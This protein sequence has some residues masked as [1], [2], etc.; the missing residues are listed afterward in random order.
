MSIFRRLLNLPSLEEEESHALP[1]LDFSPLCFFKC[2]L[3]LPAWEVAY[4]HWLQ[5]LDFSS[6]CIFQMCPQSACIRGYKVT[7]AAFIGFF[8]TVC[9]QMI[10]QTAWPRRCK[11]TLDA[12]L[13]LFSIVCLCYWNLYNGSAFSWLVLSKIWINHQ[14]LCFV[15]TGLVSLRLCLQVFVAS[16]VCHNFHSKLIIISL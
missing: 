12:F 9:F 13:R 7:L 14:H 6:L 3:K 4:S 8:S 1:L 16:V 2:V 10:P 5:L 15:V 11:V